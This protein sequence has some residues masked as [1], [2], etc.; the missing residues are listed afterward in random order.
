MTFKAPNKYRVKTG[1]YGTNK[2][3]GSNGLFFFG[4]GNVKAK[5]VCSDGEGWEHVS[6]SLDVDRCPTWEEMC[7]VKDL[8]WGEDDEVVQFHPKKKDYVNMHNYCLHLW[9]PTKEKMATPPSILVGI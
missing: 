9:K 1:Q 8:F 5:A 4:I 7:F 2:M 3:Y 6:V